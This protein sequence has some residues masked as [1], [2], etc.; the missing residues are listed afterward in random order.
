MQH[1]ELVSGVLLR[2]TGGRRL[3]RKDIEATIQAVAKT[4][5]ETVATG[6]SV[7]IRGLGT[8]LPKRHPRYGWFRPADR[9][10]ETTRRRWVTTKDN[11]LF[12]DH[13]VRKILK[14]DSRLAERWC[15]FAAANKIKTKSQKALRA[16]FKTQAN[17]PDM[18]SVFKGRLQPNPTNVIR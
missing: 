16:F 9:I 12:S 13:V 17:D 5:T 11:F 8:F 4:I 2:L 14:S 15:A 3:P 18:Q 10:Q 6:A 1:P 7:H